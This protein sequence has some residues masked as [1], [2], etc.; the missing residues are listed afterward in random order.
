MLNT[1]VTNMPEFSSSGRGGAPLPF[2]NCS[3]TV[4]SLVGVKASM[5]EGIARHLT[6][7]APPPYSSEAQ[8]CQAAPATS[9]C[10]HSA[11]GTLYSLFHQLAAGSSHQPSRQWDRGRAEEQGVTAGTWAWLRCL[12]RECSTT[13]RQR[14]LQGLSDLV[15]YNRQSTWNH[16]ATRPWYTVATTGVE[17]FA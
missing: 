3:T 14:S 5:V 15:C 8:G 1:A 9:V 10:V 6:G 2:T 16:C 12:K 11:E 13:P 17:N 4:L 7:A